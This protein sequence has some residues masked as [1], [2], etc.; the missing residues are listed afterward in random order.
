MTSSPP[1]TAPRSRAPVNSRQPSPSIGP[2]TSSTSPSREA[3]R[4]S[5]SR[6]HSA[7]GLRRLLPEHD[8]TARAEVSELPPAAASSTGAVRRGEER[9]GRSLRPHLIDARESASLR[10]RSPIGRR[11][12]GVHNSSVRAGRTGSVPGGP[13]SR[14]CRARGPQGHRAPTH[15]PLLPRRQLASASRR[16]LRPRYSAP[17]AH[18]RSS[19]AQLCAFDVGKMRG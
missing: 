1:S 14:R 17:F 13:T 4:L 5:T 9:P 8:A 10:G 3:D 11:S 15:S 16:R 18:R 7:R 2:A 6:Q 19:Q 12:S